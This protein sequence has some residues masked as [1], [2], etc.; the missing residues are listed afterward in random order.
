M[1]GRARPT[2]GSGSSGLGITAQM[3]RHFIKIIL[4]TIFL[5]AVSAPSKANPFDGPMEA[6]NQF[7]LFSHLNSFTFERAGLENSNAINFSYSSVYFVKQSTDWQA[8]LDME[9]AELNMRARRIFQDSLELGIEVPFVSFNAGFMDGVVNGFHGLFG[10]SSYG[11]Q[12]RPNNDFL[13]EVKRNGVTIVKGESG[14]FGLADI[15]L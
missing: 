2:F 14:Q 15:R 9:L 10:F 7:P 12:N 8:W 4:S 13:Y 6:K 1:S 11:R 3:P 5:I